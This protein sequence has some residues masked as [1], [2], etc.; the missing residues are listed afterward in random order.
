MFGYDPLSGY[1]PRSPKMRLSVVATLLA[2]RGATL[3]DVVANTQG[4]LETVEDI[5]DFIGEE[6]E[7]LS[8]E[9]KAEIEAQ[10]LDLGGAPLPSKRTKQ[11]IT[12]LDPLD[13]GPYL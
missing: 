2:T 10:E 6:Y 3:D 8:A 13:D 5:L 1:D 11:D 4:F 12:E 9:L 7:A